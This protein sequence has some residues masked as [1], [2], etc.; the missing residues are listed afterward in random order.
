MKLVWIILISL[1]PF[2]ALAGS[3]S[4]VDAL[5]KAKEAAMVQSGLK[6]TI[7]RYTSMAQQQLMT[8]AAT[9]HIDKPIYISLLGYKV[10][11]DKAIIVPFNEKQIVINLNSIKVVIKF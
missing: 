5:D 1:L 6:G 8:Q 2:T 3:R 9:Y 7:E 10:Y 11:K 4:Y